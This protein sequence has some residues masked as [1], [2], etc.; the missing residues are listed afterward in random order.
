[1]GIFYDWHVTNSLLS[2]SCQVEGKERKKED[3]GY[4]GLMEAVLKIMSKLFEICPKY[5][6]NF[7]YDQV[8]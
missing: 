8:S 2:E 5:K 3:E 1:M 6:R 7:I 4:Q